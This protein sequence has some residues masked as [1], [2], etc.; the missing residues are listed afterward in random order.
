[1]LSFPHFY[2]ADPEL[3]KMVDGMTPPDKEKHQLFI[4]VQPVSLSY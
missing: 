4:D 2:N 1:M 3:L